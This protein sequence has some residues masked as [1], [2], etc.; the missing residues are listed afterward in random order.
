L[1]TESIMIPRTKLQLAMNYSAFGH[2]LHSQTKIDLA[3]KAVDKVTNLL[4][5]SGNKA[6]LEFKVTDAEGE[7]LDSLIESLI[8][9][10]TLDMRLTGWISASST[11]LLS[12]VPT[13]GEKV[14]EMQS[15]V[16]KALL[17]KVIENCQ[18]DLNALK[19]AGAGEC[20]RAKLFMFKGILRSLM[21]GSAQRTRALFEKG[22]KIAQ[23]QGNCLTEGV[24]MKNQAKFCHLGPEDKKRL[25]KGAYLKF[26]QVEAFGEADTA[27]NLNI[28]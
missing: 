13:E 20:N 10:L 12:S 27:G 28:N 3:M 9:S 26:Q 11:P 17:M 6:D 4:E 25:L 22:I 16:K 23:E 8:C 18:K 2:L 7:G 14:N 5:T 21:G 1:N 15:E 19:R 24:I